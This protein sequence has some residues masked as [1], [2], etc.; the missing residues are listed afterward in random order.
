MAKPNPFDKKPKPSAA[1][2]KKGGK[3][4]K[5]GKRGC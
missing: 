2:S 1:T 5:G 4:M 3:P